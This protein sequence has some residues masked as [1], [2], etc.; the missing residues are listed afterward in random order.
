MDLYSNLPVLINKR[1]CPT[2]VEF[3]FGNGEQGDTAPDAFGHRDAMLGIELSQ[4][5]HQSLACPKVKAFTFG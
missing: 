2:P 5:A 3:F 4:Q 1:Q